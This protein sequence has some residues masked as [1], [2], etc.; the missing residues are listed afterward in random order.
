MRATQAR[1]C[2]F[3][4]ARAVVARRSP[5]GL[6]RAVPPNKPGAL[7]GSLAMDAIYAILQPLP[8][9]KPRASSVGKTRLCMSIENVPSEQSPRKGK[10]VPLS[11]RACLEGL[12]ST[13]K[14]GTLSDARWPSDP[15]W[16][17]S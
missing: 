6:D 15:P 7:D 16:K 10:I 1:A 2:G 12:V 11:V 4:S 9:A 17:P 13:L 5:S 3:A 14:V 8:L